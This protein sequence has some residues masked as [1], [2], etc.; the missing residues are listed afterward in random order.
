MGKTTQSGLAPS[1]LQ[2]GATA[3]LSG[4]CRLL[5][6][7]L[8]GQGL[9]HTIKGLWLCKAGSLQRQ[10]TVQL[11]GVPPEESDGRERANGDRFLETLISDQ[12]FGKLP[13]CD[14]E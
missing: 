10:F 4:Q 6:C 3:P 9:G 5:G 14:Y 8:S 2:K 13:D 11:P 12:C 1:S 7:N